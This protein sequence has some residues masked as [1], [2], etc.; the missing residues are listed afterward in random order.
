[1]KKEIIEILMRRDGI[2]KYEAQNI[3]EECQEEINNAIRHG[4]G[5]SAVE[6]ILANYLGLESDY[7]IAF[8][9]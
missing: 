3:I 1:M 9:E 6:D 4:Y 7:M 5:Y 2:S 8:L